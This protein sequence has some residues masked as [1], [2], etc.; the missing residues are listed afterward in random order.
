MARTSEGFLPVGVKL[1]LSLDRYQ[2]IMRL[3]IAAFNG[4][5]YPEEVNEY[6]CSTIWKQSMRNYLAQFIAQAEEI[7]EKELGFY[8]GPKYIYQEKCNLGYNPVELLKKHFVGL[9]QETSDIIKAGQALVLRD[10]GTGAIYDPVTITLATTVT[11]TDEILVTYPGETEAIHPSKVTISGGNVVIQ[12]PRSRL[13]KP[14]LNDDR[15]LHLMYDVDANFLTTVD[16]YHHYLDITKGVE[17]YYLDESFTEQTYGGYG[18][19]ESARLSLLN[20]YSVIW[21]GLT[22]TKSPIC[23]AVLRGCGEW[24]VRV[25]YMAGLR[26]TMQTETETCRLTH[27]LMPYSPCDCSPVQ[28]YWTNDRAPL[29]EGF[30]TPYGNTVGA[31]EAW[32]HDSRSR[33]GFGGIV[34]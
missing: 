26:Y 29:Q 5:N 2:E 13:V 15:D 19:I 31:L 27:T 23:P 7:R 11:N 8:L 14:A 25:S 6:Q 33:I 3:P 18:T 21:S 34:A 28:Q 20:L 32:M 30:T 9:G 17:Y 16:I 4:L 22:P 1:S 12:I 10:I 24:N